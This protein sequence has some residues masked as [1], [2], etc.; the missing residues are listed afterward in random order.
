MLRNMPSPHSSKVLH[1]HFVISFFRKAR[2]ALIPSIRWSSSAC[3]LWESVRQRSEALVESRKPKNN[4]LISVNDKAEL[5]RSLNDCESVED[6]R[7][8]PPLSANPMRRR[9]NA[10]LFVIADCGWAKPNLLRNLRNTQVHPA[11]HKP[12]PLR[13]LPCPTNSLQCRLP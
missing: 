9:K 7:I 12:K 10:D 6:G 8:V 11:H 5:A 4:C 1:W 13:S 2:T 3:F